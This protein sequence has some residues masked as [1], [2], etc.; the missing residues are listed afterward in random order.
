MADVEI[1]S[2]KRPLHGGLVEAYKNY[3]EVELQQEYER[4]SDEKADDLTISEQELQNL[5]FDRFVERRVREI[6]C[7]HT[8]KQRLEVYLEWNGILGYTESIFAFARGEIYA[9]E[10]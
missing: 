6:I 10:W 7:E 5:D 2:G 4:V 1:G 9:R 3:Y 8:P